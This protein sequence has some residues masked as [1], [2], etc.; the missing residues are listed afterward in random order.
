MF[1]KF[2]R[3]IISYSKIDKPGPCFE[4]TPTPF[5]NFAKGC[6][7]GPKC[8]YLEG[9]ILFDFNSNKTLVK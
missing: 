6:F 4:G 1:T 8:I 7:T 2:S 5:S 3:K 9:V